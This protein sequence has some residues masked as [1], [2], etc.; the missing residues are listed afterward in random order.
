MEK[1]T[2]YFQ[3]AYDEL[4]HKVTWP[5]WAELQESAVVVLITSLIISIVVL[6]IDL[7]FKSGTQELYKLIIG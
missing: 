7:A 1:F 3:E 6:L 4:V 2:L 5:T